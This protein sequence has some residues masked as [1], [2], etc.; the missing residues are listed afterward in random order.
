MNDAQGMGLEIVSLI[1]GI[2]IFV[3]GLILADI[4]ISSVGEAAGI[5]G[6]P[7]NSDVDHGAASSLNGLIPLVYYVGLAGL[8]L[9]ISYTGGKGLYDRVRN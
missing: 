1:S 3:I 8:S 4:I 5:L 9:S 6:E 2:I 7:T